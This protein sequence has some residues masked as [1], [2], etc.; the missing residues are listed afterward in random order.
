MKIASSENWMPFLLV[1]LTS[2]AG[3]G[4]DPFNTT[5]SDVQP[6]RTYRAQ[7]ISTP[8]PHGGTIR[9]MN[10]NAK[11]GGGR[12]DFF[13]DCHGDRAIMT[14]D[15]V[16]EN[17]DR[18]A[19]VIDEL[20][21]DILLLQE[22]DVA[23]KR[24][25]Y[26]DQ[27]QALLDRTGLNYGAYASQWRADYVPSDGIGPVDS[28][29]L[30]LSKY[31][32]VDATRYAL[33]EIESQDGI[34]RYFY[35]RR[36]YLDAAIDVEGTRVHA[37]NIHVSAYAEGAVKTE[38]IELFADH[39]GDLDDD[40]RI[41]VGGGD[42]NTLPPGSDKRSDFDDT[43]CENEDFIADD[44]GDEPEQIAYLWDDW[45]AAI[46]LDVYQADQARYFTHTT[47]K[48]G[49]WNR[50]LDHLFTNASFVAGSADVIQSPER[51]GIETMS[52]SDHAPVVVTL[53]LP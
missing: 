23:S 39:L 26:L 32:I 28:G 15:E 4:C 49:F 52:V 11:F 37:V 25:A 43:V 33:P 22:V 34:T 31:P 36:N 20:D 45:N 12:I 47:D 19:S 6:A 48:D 30:I 10:W 50:K 44:Y 16:D 9:V 46:P 5:F 42:L 21:P 24:A 27:A 53:E 2:F 40:G 41:W 14:A 3:L 17:L 18:L 35:L 13:F 38:Q 1:A 51:G 8:P 29:N 7:K